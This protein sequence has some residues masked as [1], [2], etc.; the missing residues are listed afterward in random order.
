MAEF[1]SVF[2]RSRITNVTDEGRTTGT[3][4]VRAAPVLVALA[5]L[6]S[7]LSGARSAAAYTIETQITQG[8]HESITIDALRRVRAMGLGAPLPYTDTDD[9]PL[10]DDAPFHVPDDFHD[11]AGATLLFGV[12]DNDVKD[13]SAAALDQLAQLTADSAGQREHCLRAVDEGEPDGTARAVAD[14]RAFIK[15]KLV[16]ALDGLGAD[17]L[18]DVHARE[19]LTVYLALRGRYTVSVP[20]FYLHAGQ[21]IHALQ[22]SFTHTFRDKADQHKIAV[23]LDWI[24][25][26]ENTLDEATEGPPHMTQLDRCDDPDDLRKQRHQLA[27]EASAAAIAAALDPKMSRDAKAAAFDR[28]LDTYVAFDASAK[29]SLANNWCNAEEN[30]YRSSGCDC[31][32]AGARTPGGLVAGTA[33]A[34][35]GGLGL[36]RRRG[37]EAR[38]GKRRGAVALASAALGLVATLARE[39]SAS[40]ADTPETKPLV[41]QEKAPLPEGQEHA[42]QGPGAALAGD[43][44]SAKLG[45]RDPAGSI[46]GHL[47]LAASYDHA[48]LAVALGGKYQ[49]SKYWMAGLDAEWNPWL[50]TQP[51]AFRAGTGNAYGSIV[52]RYQMAYEAVNFRTTAALGMSAL[53]MDLPGARKWSFG[54]LVGISFLG[55]E[56]KVAPGYY[57]VVDPTYIIVSV[58]HVTGTPL[59]YYQYRFQVG[60]EFGG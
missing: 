12:R 37:R 40:A 41:V 22:D 31:G 32:A 49:L 20:R 26:S 43:S 33:L 10:V 46:F 36:A 29:C 58:P 9:G 60:L 5:A 45:T 24:H 7:V 4:G 53:L 39:P 21:A 2:R 57:L 55:V 18:P 17:G 28:V 42:P 14:C 25:Y 13:L 23:T 11:M 6:G 50:P 19:P 52:R 27:I 38:K 30:A 35:V 54:P 47:A 15:E 16:A 56:W 51:F 44:Q 34:L 3:R 8:C 59:V 1:G 48:A